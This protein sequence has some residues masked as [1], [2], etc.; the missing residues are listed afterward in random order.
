MG[1]RAGFPGGPSEV[2]EA[3]VP[4]RADG[5]FTSRDVNSGWT[6]FQSTDIRRDDHPDRAIRARAYWSW[7][8]GSNWPPLIGS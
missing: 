5:S 3:G 1:N 2:T 8:I 7:R 4:P 6:G